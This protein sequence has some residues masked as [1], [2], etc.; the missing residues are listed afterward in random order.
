MGAQEGEARTARVVATV[1]VEQLVSLV[2]LVPDAVLLH[3]LAVDL[4]V[5]Y[6]GKLGPFAEA[7]CLAGGHPRGLIV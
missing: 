6:V 1:D 2:E 5:A 3:H 7:V 4:D